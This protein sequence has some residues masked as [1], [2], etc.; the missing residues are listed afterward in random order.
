MPFA[1][2]IDEGTLLRVGQAMRNHTIDFITPVSRALEHTYG[3]VEGSGTFVE[4]RRTPY[5]L[6]NEHVARARMVYPLAHFVGNGERAA[7]IVHPFQCITEPTDIAIARIDREV[8]AMGTKR[9]V[10]AA[11]IDPSFQPADG[12]ILFMHGFPGV[13]SHFSATY[14]G[15]LTRTFPYAVDVGPLPPG[16]DPD[17]YFALSYPPYGNVK[18]FEGD[19]T[20]LPDPAGLSGTV[21][22]DTKFVSTG[23]GWTPGHAKVAGVVFAWNQPNHCLIATKIE[24]VRQF[25]INALRREAAYFHWHLD[26]G[27]PL[28]DQLTDWGWAE[29]LVTGLD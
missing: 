22:W 17:V 24:I 15:L 19:V 26:R 9:P 20:D 1:D 13:Q 29:A 14:Q 18:T 8:L 6:T 3:E 16:F 12:E 28:W 21:V 11:R 2:H 7:R 23:A 5:I 10:P 27:E 25:L 4:L